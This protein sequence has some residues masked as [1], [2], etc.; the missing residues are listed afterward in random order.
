VRDGWFERDGVRLHYVEW[1]ATEPEE[2]D[3]TDLLLLHGLSANARYW[4]RFAARFPQRR[5]V[6]LDQRSHGS[7][8]RPPAGYDIEMIAADAAHAIR[9]TGLE[10]PVVA[11]HSWGCTTA[12]AVAA[13]HPDLVSGLVVVD[14]PVQPMSERLAWADVMRLMQPPLPRYS[15]LD[16]A[17]AQART[18]V[19]D[20][21][22][23]DLKPGVDAGFIRDGDAWVLP[24]TSGVRLQILRHMYDFQ[25]QLLWAQIEV[26]ALLALAGADV[27]MRHWKEEGAASVAEHSPGVEIR[28]YESRHDIP[29]IAPDPL[30]ADVERLCLEAGFNEVARRLRGL[31]GDFSRTANAGWNARELLAH[32]ASTQSALAAIVRAPASTGAGGGE[33]FDSNRWNASQLRKRADV[34]AGELVKEIEAGTTE[35]RAALRETDPTRVLSMGPYAGRSVASGMRAMVLHQRGHLAELESVLE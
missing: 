8:D 1:E 4:D 27:T 25:P 21:W 5:V 29:Q 16:Q 31:D 34:P 12:L 15:S 30:A 14:G 9:E 19:G 23:E 26:P 33:P 24:L 20:A 32:L 17:Y 6:A 13:L 3:G 35:L 22:A 28:W 18:Y 10:R 11:G 2:G 7:S